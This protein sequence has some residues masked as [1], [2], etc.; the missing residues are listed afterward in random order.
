MATRKDV[1]R[2]ALVL[3]LNVRAERDRKQQCRQI[4]SFYWHAPTGHRYALVQRVA[5]AR[6]ALRWLTEWAGLSN[7]QRAKLRQGAQLAI[8][9]PHY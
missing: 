2:K 6:A 1:E 4:F 3:S 7:E 9:F 5:G 8:R